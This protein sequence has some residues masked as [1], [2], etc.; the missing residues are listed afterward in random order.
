MADPLSSIVQRAIAA[1]ARAVLEGHHAFWSDR[2]ACFTVK[3]DAT[4]ATYQVRPEAIVP[5]AGHLVALSFTCTC[6]A[7][8]TSRALLPCKHAALVAR[9]LER[10]GLAWFDSG[11]WRPLGAL[12]EA[13]VA[14]TPRPIAPPA[15]A[16]MFVD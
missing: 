14:A 12:L 8:R 6:K 11:T 2:L 13:T 7:G 1:E 15:P 9:R 16:S 10:M 5:A 3:S 4:D